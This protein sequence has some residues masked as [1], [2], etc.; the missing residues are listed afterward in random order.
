M[1][2]KYFLVEYIHNN[3]AA[4]PIVTVVCSSEQAALDKFNMDLKGGFLGAPD[5]GHFPEAY[6]IKGERIDIK[7]IKTAIID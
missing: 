4:P 6:I 7:I 2:E 1:T 5:L 3:S